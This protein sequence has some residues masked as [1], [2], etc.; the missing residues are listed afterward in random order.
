LISRLV[1]L[2]N[3]LSVDDVTEAYNLIKDLEPTTPQE[4]ILK[5]V[6]NAALGQEQGSVSTG[7]SLICV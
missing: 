4:Y 5:G 3:I 1:P 7:A 2:H 6:V